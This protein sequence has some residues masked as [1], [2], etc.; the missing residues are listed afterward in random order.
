MIRYDD[1]F[2][3]GSASGTASYLVCC[4]HTVLVTWNRLAQLLM[5]RPPTEFELSRPISLSIMHEQTTCPTSDG[6]ERFEV[7]IFLP[8]AD[9]NAV[10]HN[11][12]TLGF[13]E[14]PGDVFAEGVRNYLVG[15]ERVE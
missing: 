8:L 7:A 1:R 10:V 4:C 15:F 3:I 14:L 2:H 13:E 6:S 9:R 11:L 5:Q 12:G